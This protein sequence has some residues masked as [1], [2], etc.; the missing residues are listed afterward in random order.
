MH[1]RSLYLFLPFFFFPCPIKAIQCGE[2]LQVL[3]GGLLVA[4]PHAV[5]ASRAP[6]GLKVRVRVRVCV[7]VCLCVCACACVCVRVRV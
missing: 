3:T 7:R 2:C 6:D 1:K 4:T 5:R